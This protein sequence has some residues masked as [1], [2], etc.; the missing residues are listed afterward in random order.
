MVVSVRKDHSDSRYTT[1]EIETCCVSW[2]GAHWN[3]FGHVPRMSKRLKQR[4]RLVISSCFFLGAGT[5]TDLRPRSTQ[6][7]MRQTSSDSHKLYLFE[8]SDIS[9][10]KWMARILSGQLTQVSKQYEFPT[11]RF[12]PGGA[13]NL[14]AAFG[15]LQLHRILGGMFSSQCLRA[16]TTVFQSAETSCQQDEAL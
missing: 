15:L 9:R 16:L 8:I 3:W 10:A 14:Y 13:I 7:F 4:A 1:S 11:L 6:Q 12:K 2:P 5:P